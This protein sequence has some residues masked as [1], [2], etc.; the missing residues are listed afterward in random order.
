MLLVGGI[1]ID[2]NKKQIEE[3]QPQIFVGTPGRVHDMI[4]RNILKTK[5]L[6][7]LILDEADEMLSTGFKEQMSKILTYMPE[8]IKVGLFSATMSDELFEITKLFMTNPIK[9]LVKNKELTLQGIAQY[10]VNLNDDSDKY[11]T[12]KTFS[13]LTIS[14]SIIYCNSTR[15]VDDLEEAMLKIITLLKKLW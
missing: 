1:S 11:D 13:T 8:S 5:H 15:R 7:L 2:V 4:R 12:L 10:Y 9:I 6:K 3:I 14:Q